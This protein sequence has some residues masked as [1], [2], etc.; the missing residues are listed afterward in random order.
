[1]SA[2]RSAAL[3][4][5]VVVEPLSPCSQLSGSARLTATP[6]PVT[7]TTAATAPVARGV[8][9]GS[10]K[11]SLIRSRGFAVGRLVRSEGRAGEAVGR[12]VGTVRVGTLRTAAG[13]A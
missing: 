4:C 13:D 10:E 6:T 7:A 5:S 8:Q 11:R 9:D 1:M 2:L 12:G 3:S